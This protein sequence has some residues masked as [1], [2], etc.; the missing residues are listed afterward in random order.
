MTD[1]DFLDR[2]NIMVLKGDIKKI[3]VDKKFI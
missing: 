3:D 1:M 2:A